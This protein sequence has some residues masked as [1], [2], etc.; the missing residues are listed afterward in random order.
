MS[1]IQRRARILPTPL[2][3]SP[4]PPGTF[5]KLYVPSPGALTRALA[6]VAVLAVPGCAPSDMERN[7]PTVRLE[8]GLP[9]GP[10]SAE[11]FL[12]TSGDTVYLSWLEPEGEGHALRLATRVAGGWSEPSTVTA[13]EDFFVNWADF[14]SVVPGPD[15]T[16]W[17]HWLQRG[18]AGGYDYGVRVA[19][20]RDGGR[21][22]SEPLRPHDDDSPQE[23]GFVAFVPVEGGLGAVWLDGRRYE[24]GPDGGA[25]TEEMTVRYRELALD[26]E[27]GA[28][29]P[30]GPEVLLD[31]RA[32]DCCQTDAVATSNG[33]LVVYRDRTEGE[34]RDIHVVRRVD[35]AWTEPAPV[36]RDG[37]EI[38]GCPVNGPAAAA[39]EDAVAVAWFTGAGNEPRVKVAF[40]TDAGASF[41][42]PVVVDDGTPVGRVDVV[43]TADGSA[44][45]TWLEQ[46]GSE[47][48]E[49][50]M[51]RVAPDGVAGPSH[52]LATT[53]SAR[54][55]GFPRVAA[56]DDSSLLLAWTGVEDD[57][58]TRV[59]AAL[60][61]VPSP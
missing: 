42:S 5:P 54:R 34:I 56:L 15:G 45:V 51:R 47:G 12:S 50:R 21:S 10:G 40:S 32:C 38:G 58:T 7:E 31:G 55:S 36:A 43:L 16:L 14:P 20:S 1:V 23:H 3:R 29:V 61:E 8:T 9:T 39:R 19:A 59:R 44:L 24:R 37:W 46:T 53:S 22:W 26:E 60:V 11:P 28:P 49:V 4:Y 25:P 41:G 13:R 2:D 30:G 6:L 35:G 27:G 17:T 18:S 48:A 52:T 57:G 33:P